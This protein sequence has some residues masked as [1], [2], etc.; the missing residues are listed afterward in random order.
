M[1]EL[2]KETKAGQSAPASETQ[3][4]KRNSACPR[5]KK[6]KMDED[7]H[8]CGR[9]RRWRQAAWPGHPKAN[10]YLGGSY[11][12]AQATRQGS[13]AVRYWNGDPEARRFL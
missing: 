13:D 2:M 5:R 4:R 12:V 10:A 1:E 9:D 7:R 6:A 11:L 3:S 8:C